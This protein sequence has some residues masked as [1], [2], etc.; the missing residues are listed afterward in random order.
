MVRRP[1]RSTEI[2]GEQGNEAGKQTAPARKQART[3]GKSASRT[4]IEQI[5]IGG[6][7]KSRSGQLLYLK[8]DAAGLRGEVPNRVTRP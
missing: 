6:R 8:E 2:A 5:D 1:A 4:E 3:S 7:E